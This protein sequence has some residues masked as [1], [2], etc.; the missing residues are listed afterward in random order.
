M[1]IFVLYDDLFVLPSSPDLV[2]YLFLLSW[3]LLYCAYY[4]SL[5]AVYL[6]HLVLLLLLH[7]HLSP[8]FLSLMS[9]SFSLCSP[10]SSFFSHLL[11]VPG[12]RTL[13]CLFHHFARLSDFFSSFRNDLLLLIRL[14]LFFQV[15][16][17]KLVDVIIDWFHSVDLSHCFV[18]TFF[19]LNFALVFLIFGNFIL[20]NSSTN[21]PL[22]KTL[23][24][25][26]F[27]KLMSPLQILPLLLI[28]LL[29]QHQLALPFSFL[30][31]SNFHKGIGMKIL[32]LLMS[33]LLNNFL[34]SRMHLIKLHN[35][36]F[37]RNMIKFL[38]RYLQFLQRLKRFIHTI[39]FTKSIRICLLQLLY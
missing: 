37:P 32:K 10:Q 31:M 13:L 15:L 29:P 7:N 3:C 14:S 33:S 8:P 35:K 38:F 18:L 21:S 4:Y 9:S 17:L 28:K 16:F 27:P 5:S 39:C 2:L 36:K 22:L 26:I 20:S 6:H 30:L 19:Q 12:L 11:S 34:L 23:S 24:L 25:P 1:K